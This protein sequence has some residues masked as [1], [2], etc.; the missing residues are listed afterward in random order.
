M[1]AY[2]AARASRRRS[3]PTGRLHGATPGAQYALCGAAVR[4]PELETPAF[5]P[6]APD[7]CQRCALR[8]RAPR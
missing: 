7:A 6:E 4:P 5:D 3:R 2:R 8:V 1:T